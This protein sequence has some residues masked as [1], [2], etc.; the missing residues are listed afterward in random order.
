MRGAKP[1]RQATV[2]SALLVHHGAI[3]DGV[4]LQAK[5]VNERLRQIGGT[6]K[7]VLD[8]LSYAP[9]YE[10]AF[11]SICGRA[12]FS[13]LRS[14]S[15]AARVMS[16]SHLRTRSVPPCQTSFTCP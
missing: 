5:P 13:L 8:I 16:R 7:L 6:A 10:R 12:S 3:P 1:R 2:P 15:S 11:L 4:L 9:A 14:S